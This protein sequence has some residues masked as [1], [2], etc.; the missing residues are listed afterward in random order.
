M[1]F[2][3]AGDSTITSDAPELPPPPPCSASPPSSSSPKSGPSSS[4]APREARAPRVRPVDLPAERFRVLPLPVV[5]LSAIV[6]VYR[7]AVAGADVV[8]HSGALHECPQVV[9]GDA[10]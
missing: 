5:F 1:V 8:E 9:E 6:S 7:A 2:A 3:L 4:T 10:S